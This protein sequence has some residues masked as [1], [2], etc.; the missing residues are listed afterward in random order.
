MS[1][2]DAIKESIG[3]EQLIRE[4][5]SNSVLKEEYLI[6]DTHPDVQEILT[7]EA[8]PMIVSKELV[9][10]KI[11]LEGKVEY[12]VLYLARE[13]GLVANSVNYTEKFTS[14]IDLNQGEHKVVCEVECKVEHIEAAIMNER[15]IS[16]Q[17]IFGIDWEIY[18]SSEFEF[19]KDIEGTDDIEILKKTETINR[20]SGSEE[21]ELSGKSTIR[22][23]MDKPQ[24]NKI[25]KCSL[26]LHKKEIKILED[27]IYLSC[28][29]KLNILYKGDDSRELISIEDD[30]YLSKEEE[31]KGVNS[32]MMY[33]V[34]YD[35][36]NNDLM[37]EE[38]D[39]GEV[40]I[41]NN[42]FL[43]KANVKVFS[44]ENIDVIKDAYSPKFLIELRKDEYELGAI[45][46]TNSS[47]IMVKD[48]I[49]LKENNL[50]PDQIISSNASVIITDKQVEIDKVIVDGILKVD[51][52]YKTSDQDKYVASVK[53]EIPFTSIVDIF[54]AR[55]GMKAIIRNNL[56][57]IDTTIEANTIAV[58]ATVILSA[59]ICYE[60]KKQFISDVIEQDG[61]APEKKASVTIYVV[62][63]EDTLWDLAKK[64]NTTV[65]SLLKINN[66]EDPE[67]IEVGKK[68]IIPGRAIF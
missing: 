27:K 16:I 63:E 49:P 17:G 31:L 26:L 56:E 1:Q 9:G 35:I 25:L 46:G 51:I 22:V 42:E 3:F 4:S 28:Y 38:D 66:I 54:G 59:K 2:I 11:V 34:S 68:I 20:I 15:K 14:N 45:Q 10:D 6:P 29:C 44:K 30:V 39:L 24:I 12:T 67:Y 60:M 58:K 33:S 19:V 5:N 65:A 8:R 36:V 32:E 21:I 64:Y 57:N 61:E 23:G 52:L 62:G 18:K 37:L 41:I 47:E 53:S 7:V 40:R 50:K 43:V 13:E 55:D 48:N